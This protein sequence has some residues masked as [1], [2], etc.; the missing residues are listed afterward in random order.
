MIDGGR[1]WNSPGTPRDAIMIDL[2]EVSPGAVWETQKVP[3][4]GVG[5]RVGFVARE[6]RLDSAQKDLRAHGYAAMADQF[7][8]E[9]CNG[10]FH[11][12][13]AFAALMRAAMLPRLT[14]FPIPA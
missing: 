5:E 3:A 6:D 13:L 4:E 14:G 10:R 12:P 7:R 8:I 11:A 1:L 9:R 2:T